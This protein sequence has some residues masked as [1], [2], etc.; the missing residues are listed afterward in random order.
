M[1]DIAHKL[2]HDKYRK[3]QAKDGVVRYE[4]LVNKKDR[5]AFEAMVT[6]VAKELVEPKGARLRKAKAR[7]ELFSQLVSGISHEFFELK[8]QIT[9]LKAKVKALSPTLTLRKKEKD[10]PIPDSIKAL[11]D[12]PQELKKLLAQLSLENANLRLKQG[13]LEEKIE[14]YHRINQVL[15]KNSPY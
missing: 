8:D 7:S 1:K 3:K 4:I 6:D 11:P 14:R 12:E 15:S 10:L 13:D 9:V 5:D 2:S